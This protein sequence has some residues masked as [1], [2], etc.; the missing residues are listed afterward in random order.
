MVREIGTAPSFLWP[1]G[2]GDSTPKM[3]TVAR[4]YC[5]IIDAYADAEET[6]EFILTP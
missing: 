3:L 6:K 4:V 2:D 1:H 5:I